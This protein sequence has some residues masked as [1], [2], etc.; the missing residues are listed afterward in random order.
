MPTV[1]ARRC[2][3]WDLCR[4]RKIRHRCGSVSQ[5]VLCA[6]LGVLQYTTVSA[7]SLLSV[8]NSRVLTIY[9]IGEIFYDEATCGL[10]VRVCVEQP[11]CG[12][13]KMPHV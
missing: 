9:A 5:H 7:D 2:A 10:D 3:T 1:S 8:Y 12:L 6:L 11:A 13:F 4:R